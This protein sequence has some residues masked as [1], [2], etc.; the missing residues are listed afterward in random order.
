MNDLN[1]VVRYNDN[2]PYLDSRYTTTIQEYVEII[3]D[4]VTENDVA[5][6]KDIA[7]MRGVTRASVSMVIGSLR[8]L[9]LVEHEH[10]GDVLLTKDGRLLGEL[11]DHRH[12]LICR[13]CSALSHNQRMKK[14]ADWNIQ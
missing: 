14:P 11:L 6:V 10:Y 9:G 4:L 8:E 5:R 13:T 7:E 12:K 2:I 1:R 3:R